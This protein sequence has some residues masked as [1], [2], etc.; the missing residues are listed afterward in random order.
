VSRIADRLQDIEPFHV[1]ALLARAKQLE[2]EGKSIIHMEI[3]EPDFP[4]APGIVEAGI[5]ALE[6]GKTKYTPA[7]GLPALRELIATSYDNHELPQPLSASRVV[8][9]PGASGA[10][11][12][13]CS[14]LINPGDEVIMS[15]PTYPCNRHFVRLFEGKAVSVP[16]NAASA[17]Q[18]TAAMI[19]ANW[20][21]KTVA[22]LLASPSNPAG[23][24]I[25][26]QELR[27]IATVVKTRGGILIV[28]EIYHGL[29]YEAEPM[30]APDSALAL[31]CDV[32]VINSFSKYYG[33]TGWRLGWLVA[34]EQTL[35]AIERLAQNFFLAA[36]TV[37]QYAA[38][39]AFTD[40][41]QA[42]L[43]SRR[44]QFRLRRDYLCPA[45]EQLGFKVPVLPD[46][47]F[48]V[49]CDA[50]NFTNN[51]EQFC[52]SLLEEAGVAVTPGKDFGTFGASDHV[53]FSY[54]NTIENLETGVARIK[55]FLDR[56]K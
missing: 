13:V 21:S 20:T 51:S 17:Y 18:L 3:G 14:V 53:R 55:K 56:Q 46:G 31:D 12:L 4:T 27:A 34:P 22:V 54:A 10:L 37:A 19:E 29:T 49:Y 15:D 50:S 45:L 30:S 5:K 44:D 41:V 40:D 43:G 28:D 35:P 32:F 47:A 39:A 7:L 36:P 11:Q 33:M 1:M 2:A 48:Y 16:V 24:L 52:T 23:T 42:E 25:P 9:T 38:L 6:A 26:D 8:V